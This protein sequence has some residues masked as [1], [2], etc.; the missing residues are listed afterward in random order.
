[1]NNDDKDQLNY[2]KGLV[3]DASIAVNEANFHRRQLEHEVEQLVFANGEKLGRINDLEKELAGYRALHAPKPMDIQDIQGF[4]VRSAALDERIRVASAAARG[5]PVQRRLQMI[6][7]QEEMWDVEVQLSPPR[8]RRRTQTI[9]LREQ[10]RRFNDTN[11]AGS[12][13]IDLTKK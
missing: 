5:I 9:M 7:E 8:R 11:L 12:T 13:Q 1:M 10:E 2:W 3:E 4:R 6:E